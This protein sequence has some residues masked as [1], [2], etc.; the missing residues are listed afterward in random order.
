MVLDRSRKQIYSAH[1][2]KETSMY[3]FALLFL[4]F[5][6]SAL[7]AYGAQ[8]AK[9]VCRFT[10]EHLNFPGEAPVRDFVVPFAK[11]TIWANNDNLKVIKAVITFRAA[12]YEFSIR[13]WQPISEEPSIKFKNV[14]IDATN[15]NT[16]VQHFG[17][18]SDA[19][20]VKKDITHAFFNISNHGSA[21]DIRDC[22]LE[23]NVE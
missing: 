14:V 6:F 4:T 16:A 1:I 7:S 8:E 13:A 9:L 20:K 18:E 19:M 5:I 17:G 22:S 10:Q 21:H 11:G 23:C 15:L 12:N 2:T 3:K